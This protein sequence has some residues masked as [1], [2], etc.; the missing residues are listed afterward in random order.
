MS[1]KYSYKY[2]L[3]AKKKYEVVIITELNSRYLPL[4]YPDVSLH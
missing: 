4:I 3:S 2:D 1:R